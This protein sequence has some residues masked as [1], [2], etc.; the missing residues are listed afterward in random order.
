LPVVLYRCETWSLILREKCRLKVFG[1]RMLRIIFG[2]KR[3]EIIGGWIILHSEEL[4]NLNFSPNIIRMI[5]TRKMKWAGH[6]AHMW[7]RVMHI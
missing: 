4:H 7:R 2:P 6:V 1:N 3:N 5:K